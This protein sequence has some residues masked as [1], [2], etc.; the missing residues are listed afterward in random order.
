MPTGSRLVAYE[1]PPKSVK[2]VSFTII[3]FLWKIL[4]N[5]LMSGFTVSIVQVKLKR[6]IPYIFLLILS[7]LLTKG[8][9]SQMTLSSDTLYMYD[10]TNNLLQN[11]SFFDWNLTQAADY[12]PDMILYLILALFI[13]SASTQILLITFS[14]V[15]TLAC[16]FFLIFQK[17]GFKQVQA[18]LQASIL[19]SAI[20]LFQ[21]LSSDWIFFYRPNNHFSS[22]SVGLFLV[23]SLLN[24]IKKNQ[25][26]SKTFYVSTSILIFLGT[27]ST[28]TFVYAITI[29]LIL[30][31]LQYMWKLQIGKT[32]FSRKSQ[33]YP[34]LFSFFGSTFLAIFASSL[35]N[36]SNNLS[37]R[38]G[39]SSGSL[40]SLK[41]LAMATYSR[42]LLNSGLIVSFLSIIGL[43]GIFLSLFS[44][45]FLKNYWWLKFCPDP[46]FGGLL[47][48]GIY[49][50]V[51]SLLFTVLSGGIIDVYFLRYFWPSLFLVFIAYVAII[52]G[53]IEKY[54]KKIY[55]PNTLG[56]LLLVILLLFLYR[57]EKPIYNQNTPHQKV[58]KCISNLRNE[59]IPLKAGVSDYWYGRSID[60]L[61]G[62]RFR[63]YV[64]WNT[65]KPYYWMTTKQP[66]VDSKM[67]NNQSYNYIL[68]HTQPSPPFNFGV[69]QMT[70]ILPNPTDKFLC[71]SSDMVI[72]YYNNGLLDLI[73]REKIQKFLKNDS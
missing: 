47:S 70:A 45:F 41:S 16:L 26:I 13:H 50:L 64:A 18:F 33:L 67:Y 68:L 48:L 55:R 71:D 42:N 7:F 32:F 62:S 20:S 52:T 4:D 27:V 40:N 1:E 69:D 19:L 5:V 56:L 66:F 73:V 54:G 22:A 23:F 53:V 3:E 58:A 2:T 34:V 61:S 46:V 59:G 14:Q 57:V 44:F 9:E 25:R 49:S 38:F 11:G 24:E 63:S 35:L 17:I 28:I 6:Y 30:V 60:Y 43:C 72:W 8:F 36:P 21:L 10:L 12:F 37:A 39:L 51:T 29:P 15:T 65:L 31:L